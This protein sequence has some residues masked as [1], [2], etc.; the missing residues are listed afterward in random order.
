MNVRVVVADER[1]AR[2]FDA[3]SPVAPLE[4]RGTIVNE[5]ATLHDRDLEADR[6]GVFSNRGAPGRH[7]MDGDRSTKRHE[8]EQFAR[9]IARSLDDARAR[10][11][12]ERL[13]IVAG[14]RMLGW[15]RNALPD[16]SRSVVVAE[17][18]KDLVHEDPA[19]IR[20]VVPREAFFH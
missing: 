8:M 19:M 6:Y 20:E 1:E 11:E 17:I 7:G 14:P 4:M 10:N 3:H 12:F 5:T 18:G 9:A 16:P 2:L 15:L 13:V